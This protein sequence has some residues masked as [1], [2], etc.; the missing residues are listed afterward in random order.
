M[1]VVLLLMISLWFLPVCTIANVDLKYMP[2]GFTVTNTTPVVEEGETISLELRITNNDK[3][4]TWPV[5]IPGADN[6]GRKVFFLTAY[7]VNDKNFYTEIAREDISDQPALSGSVCGNAKV[8]QLKPGAH[9]DVKIKLH[10]YPH[11]KEQPAERHWF[12]KPLTAGSYQLMVWYHPWGN[13][14]FDLYTYSDWEKDDV[15]TGKL[16][17]SQHGNPTMY[18]GVVVNPQNLSALPKGVAEYCEL[19]CSFCKHV[20]NA[21]WDAVKRQIHATVQTMNDRPRRVVPAADTIP[22]LRRH[23][24]VVYLATPPTEIL[25]IF[26]ARYSQKVG[27]MSK[28]KVHYFDMTFQ[29]GKINRLNSRVSAGWRLLFHGRNPLLNISDEDYFGLS[30]FVPS[31]KP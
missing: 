11:D 16:V 29:M 25:D 12:A 1:R 21:N 13:V 15:P 17:F 31:G 7:T 10:S 5:M 22:W 23:K 9:I 2:L 4:S 20:A 3:D 14:P 18:C 26:P 30:S 6:S 19:G 28:G 27:F 24:Q 8:I